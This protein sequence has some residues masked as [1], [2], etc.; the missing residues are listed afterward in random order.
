VSSAPSEFRYEALFGVRTSFAQR[1]LL[2]T[3]PIA[4]ARRAARAPVDVGGVRSCAAVALRGGARLLGII[5]IYR[6]EVH[7]FSDKQIARLQNFAARR[8]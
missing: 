4:S 6:R 8:S 2:K 5:A 1:N 7:P 3:T